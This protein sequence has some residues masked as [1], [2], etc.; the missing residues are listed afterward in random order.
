MF[1]ESSEA[2]DYVGE[3][4]AINS[5]VRWI[6]TRS[7][8]PI[9]AWMMAQHKTIH[10]QFVW[11][12]YDAALPEKDRVTKLFVRALSSGLF[13]PI[14]IHNVTGTYPIP[15]GML[16]YIRLEE[17]PTVAIRLSG[18]LA[19]PPPSSVHS[20]AMVTKQINMQ[21]APGPLPAARNPKPNAFNYTVGNIVHEL[22]NRGLPMPSKSQVA[23]ILNDEKRLKV[24]SPDYIRG[25]V[26]MATAMMVIPAYRT[27]AVNLPRSFGDT[28]F[29]DQL[30]KHMNPSASTATASA[31]HTPN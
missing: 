17:V 30:I 7:A 21:Y 28:R 9:P 19:L 31:S 14:D 23:Y 26:H 5:A 4:T 20:A 25:L 16:S 18:S 15:P 29:V 11:E 13:I 12:A 3:F 1:L 6:V 8:D 24:H 2:A 22:T 10:R 27:C